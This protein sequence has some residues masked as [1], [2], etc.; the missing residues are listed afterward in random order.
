MHRGELESEAAQELRERI[1]ELP[2]LLGNAASGAL[3][4]KLADELGWASTYAAEYVELRGCRR[5]ST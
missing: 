5:T 1:W 4:W 3:A 2:R